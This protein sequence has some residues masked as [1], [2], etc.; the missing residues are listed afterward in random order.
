MTVSHAIRINAP[1]RNDHGLAVFAVRRERLV[2]DF[3]YEIIT[4][5]LLCLRKHCLVCL[6]VLLR[7]NSGYPRGKHRK[8]SSFVD[9]VSSAIC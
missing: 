6:Q 9:N 8:S 2:M 5:A 4:T 1:R 7:N 3:A